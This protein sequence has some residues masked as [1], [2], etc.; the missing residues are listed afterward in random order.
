MKMCIFTKFHNGKAIKPRNVPLM[1]ATSVIA[2]FISLI[3]AQSVSI[4]VTASDQSKL[5][6]KQPNA[7]FGSSNNSTKITLN[8]AVRYQTI[9]GFG[10]CMTEGSAETIYSLASKQQDSL[11]NLLFN[12]QT[13]GMS[14][15]RITVGASDLGNGTYTYSLVDGDTAMDHFNF[16]GVDSTYLI[17]I[18]KKVVAINPKIKI[19]AS[20]WTP[21]IWMKTN[22]AYKGGSLKTQYYPAY[23]KYW[24]KYIKGMKAN[25]I[26]IWAMTIQN[27]PLNSNN[28]PSCVWTQQQEATFDN[29][30]LGPAFKAAGITTKIIAYDHN[31]DVTAYP[32]YVCTTST[33]VDGA[34]F[35]L[36]SGSITA[37]TTVRN[38]TKK[39]VYFTEQCTCSDNFSGN[40]SGHM[41]NVFMGSLTN[42]GRCV[43]E[44]NLSTDPDLGPH[45]NDGGCGVCVGAVMVNNATSFTLKASY[46]TFATFSKIIKTDA[47]RIG[48]TSTEADLLNVAAIND[49]GT[50][51]MVV[52]NN[53][54]SSRS[55]D[56][57]WNGQAAPFT[58]ANNAAASFLWQGP[59]GAEQRNKLVPATKAFV[60]NFPEPFTSWTRINLFLTKK[61]D[62]NVVVCNSKGVVVASLMHGTHAQGPHDIMWNGTDASGRPVSAGVYV[63]NFTTAGFSIA[64]RILKQ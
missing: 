28:T 47:I 33:Y 63:V 57:V 60:R 41:R 61:A 37:M 29:N 10:A 45:T 30:Y 5:L 39:N 7:T 15:M 23:A 59:V 62:A 8:E 51:A 22:N 24:V 54:G 26:P 1:L 49:D 42:W 3:Q 43:I 2:C 48:T 12:L 34:A 56:V 13:G 40:Y 6:Q 53:T 4:W 55:F 35:H 58:L 21:P 38:A 19:L 25:G 16:K 36:Y 32:I 9:D 44:W 14:V 46:Y 31:C 11:L 27:E 18:L 20:P 17:P 50:R 64:K 52:Y